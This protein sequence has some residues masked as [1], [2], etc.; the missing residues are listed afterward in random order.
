[1]FRS[2][3][4]S[5]AMFAVT[6]VRHLLWKVCSCKRCIRQQNLLTSQTSEGLETGAPQ[7]AKYLANLKHNILMLW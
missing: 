2:A 6:E 3:T 4:K 7:I 1:M 5:V